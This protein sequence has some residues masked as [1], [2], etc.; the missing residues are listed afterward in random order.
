[1]PIYRNLHHGAIPVAE[2]ARWGCLGVI[3]T[4]LPTSHDALDQVLREHFL[5]E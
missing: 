1:V 4:S 3:R 2:I 5:P